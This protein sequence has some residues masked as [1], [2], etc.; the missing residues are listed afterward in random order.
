MIEHT[1][2]DQLELKSNGISGQ[3]CTIKACIYRM[4]R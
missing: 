1:H 4:I 2:I 3:F